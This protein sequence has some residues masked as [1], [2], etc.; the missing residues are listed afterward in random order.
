MLYI[1]PCLLIR[2]LFLHQ[3]LLLAVTV[4]EIPNS[5]LSRTPLFSGS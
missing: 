1:L 5:F 2:A 3:V 4:A